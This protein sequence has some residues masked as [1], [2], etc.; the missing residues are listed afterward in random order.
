MKVTPP[1]EVGPDGT[2][3]WKDKKGRYHR[4]DGP[5]IVWLDGSKFWYF[6]GLCHRTDGP[7]VE[8]AKSSTWPA[9]KEWRIRGKSLPYEEFLKH[10]ECTARKNSRKGETYLSPFTGKIT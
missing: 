3:Y 7:A 9:S 5:A 8:R 10:P 4:E 1:A 2:K 6:D